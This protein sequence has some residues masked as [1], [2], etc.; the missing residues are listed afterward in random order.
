VYKQGCVPIIQTFDSPKV[1]IATRI[2][3]N[4]NPHPNPN[5]TLS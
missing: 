1:Y 5:P 2:F 3:T 4:S